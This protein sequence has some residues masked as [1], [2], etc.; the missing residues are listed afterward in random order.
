MCRNHAQA[1]TVCATSR[2]YKWVLQASKGLANG[3]LII[4]AWNPLS[5]EQAFSANPPRHR[6]SP[7]T[8]RPRHCS[9]ERAEQHRLMR[10]I[11]HVTQHNHARNSA[12]PSSQSP[13]NRSATFPYHDP[14]TL[15]ATRVCLVPGFCH[16][17]SSRHLAPIQ[18]AAVTRRHFRGG[19]PTFSIPAGNQC[20]R[21]LVRVRARVMGRKYAPT[22]LFRWGQSAPWKR[23]ECREAPAACVFP[24]LPISI[25]RA[26]APKP[27][28]G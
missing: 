9:Q 14:R 10:G 13:S 19:P 27:S 8:T 2:T 17:F 6:R 15:M 24:S 28:G 5:R 4:T 1:L 3:P 16:G 18:L 21:S 22:K 7:T 20:S 26:S 23:L 25:E 12:F 11:L